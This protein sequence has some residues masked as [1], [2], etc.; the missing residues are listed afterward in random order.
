MIWDQILTILMHCKLVYWKCEEDA[1]AP[2][3]INSCFD[4]SGQQ[5]AT[6]GN[7]SAI[8]A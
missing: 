5:H 6:R 7:N 4:L 8:L 1:L 3:V 2:L